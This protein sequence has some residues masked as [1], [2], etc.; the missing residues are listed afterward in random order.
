MSFMEKPTDPRRFYT[1]DTY[2]RLR[3]IKARVDPLDLF[4]AN[5][6]V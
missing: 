4:H 5:H 6:P 1:A 3:A 2:R